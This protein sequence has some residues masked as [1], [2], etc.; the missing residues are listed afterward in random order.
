M[1]SR[2]L[3]VVLLITELSNCSWVRIAGPPADIP[4]NQKKV[5]DHN[6]KNEVPTTSLKTS[7][8]EQS[9]TTVH[10][11]D[12]G[13]STST[14][15]TSTN[16]PSPENIG[17]GHFLT[18]TTTEEDDC[19]GYEAL[20][21]VFPQKKVEKSLTDISPRMNDSEIL[22][23]IYSLID[24]M[25]ESMNKIVD[26][27]VFAVKVPESFDESDIDT[28]WNFKEEHTNDEIDIKLPKEIVNHM[29][30]EKIDFKIAI[31]THFSHSSFNTTTEKGQS[32][33]HGPF[34]IVKTTS[35]DEIS[36][37]QLALEFQ[38]DRKQLEVPKGKWN[39]KFWNNETLDWDKRGISTIKDEN[40]ITCQSSHLSAFSVVMDPY[41]GTEDD[42]RFLTVI[43]V[44]GSLLTIPCLII[45]VIMYRHK[46]ARRKKISSKILMNC[47]ASLLLLHFSFLIYTF[48]REIFPCWLSNFLVHYGVS[49]TLLWTAA[50]GIN[51]WRKLFVDIF[52]KTKT[53]FYRWCKI[54]SWGFPL[55]ASLIGV[56]LTDYSERDECGIYFKHNLILYLL[57][58]ALIMICNVIFFAIM[59][60]NVV[61]KNKI[62]SLTGRK[63][64][65]I[66][67]LVQ[68]FG[69]FWCIAFPLMWLG[70]TRFLGHLVFT[71][72]VANQ[73]IVIFFVRCMN[74]REIRNELME[75][76]VYRK[77]FHH[78]LTISEEK[79]SYKNGKT[80]VT[81]IFCMSTGSGKCI[82]TSTDM[83]S[84]L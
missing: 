26:D 55:L 14:T 43:S 72:L 13:K 84:R 62:K 67:S 66:M 75:Y 63:K 47:C 10:Q 17:C 65:Y 50:D 12:Q 30:F 49:S 58:G 70:E 16:S 32:L 22:N 59:F 81:G 27:L 57:P 68:V 42:D 54:I 33:K 31:L 60:I 25:D 18:T 38:I 36:I 9:S 11:Q 21:D 4:N 40:Y 29:Y 15:T 82:L 52:D 8:S 61:C 37:G 34:I 77:I 45:T 6:T 46:R 28:V 76:T 1:Y 64:K 78:V 73:G 48:F 24:D 80:E 69:L 39:C 20:Q 23:E 19:C 2:C 56:I 74:E 3:L 44:L 83:E 5:I 71:I 7:S 79:S 51:M 41:A 53:V 35:R